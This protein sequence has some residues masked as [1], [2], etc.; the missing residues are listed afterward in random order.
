MARTKNVPKGQEL[1]NWQEEVGAEAK[2]AA[3]NVIRAALEDG[4][5]VLVGEPDPA[6]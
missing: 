4:R 5:A 6:A 3:S 1:A 2:A